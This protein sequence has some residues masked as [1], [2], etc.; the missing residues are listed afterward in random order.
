MSETKDQSPNE[1]FHV[2]GM[3]SM[4]QSPANAN[5]A[6]RIIQKEEVLEDISFCRVIVEHIWPERIKFLSDTI[7][8]YIELNC[9]EPKALR[10]GTFL[11]VVVRVINGFPEKNKQELLQYMTPVLQALSIEPSSD[12]MKICWEI[13]KW[14]DQNHQFMLN[15]FKMEDPTK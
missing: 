14:L 6:L 4:L 10:D 2:W 13:Y 3:T 5:F 15:K 9:D 7:K 12:I 1:E 8:S 11:Y